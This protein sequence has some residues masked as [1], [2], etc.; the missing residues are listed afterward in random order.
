MDVLWF[1][2]TKRPDEGGAVAGRLGAGQILVML[3]RGEYWQV[4]YVI[5]KGSAGDI[6]GRSIERFRHDVATVAP[7]LADRVG[8]IGDWDQVR[9]LTVRADRLTRWHRPGYLAIGDAAHAMSPIGGV[10]I[11]VAIHDAV[12][13]ANLLWRPLKTG[14]LAETHLHAV[15]KTRE[16]SVRLVQR[17]QSV[18]QDRFL[19]PTLEAASVPTIPWA[20]KIVARLPFLREIP[21]RLIGFGVGRP[22]VESPLAAG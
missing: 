13:A 6:R 5:P 1:R 14:S 22:R 2:V 16:R 15:Q 8:Q 9:L 18:V 20:L 17:F 10:G 12:V 3:D 19:R 21:P 7:E 4:A 11:N